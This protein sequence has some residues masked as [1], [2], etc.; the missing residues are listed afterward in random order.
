MGVEEEGAING[1]EEGPGLAAAP[2]DRWVV[3]RPAQ[4]SSRP[5]ARYKVRAQFCSDLAVAVLVSDLP[6]Y[7]VVI[8][9]PAGAV[10]VSA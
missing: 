10:A 4:G 5:S 8:R 2:H 3:L 7:H 6:C 9:P 1:G